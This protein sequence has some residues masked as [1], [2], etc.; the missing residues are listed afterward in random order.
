[1]MSQEMVE[2]SLSRT[3]ENL[4]AVGSCINLSQEGLEYTNYVQ[5][6]LTSDVV[7][8]M[9]EFTQHGNTS[10]FQHCVNVSY[11]SY[12]LCDKLGLDKKSAARAGLLHDLFLY[13]WHSNTEKMPLFQKHG[14]THPQKALD[15]ANQYFELNEKEEDM[16]LKHMW[17]LTISLPKYKESCIIILVDKMCCLLEFFQG[18]FTVPTQKQIEDRMLKQA[19]KE[20]EKN[21]KKSA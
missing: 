20:I 5:D 17:P 14:F 2:H 4:F 13:D 16:I 21:E 11:Y 8:S 6:L 1:M 18:I 15:N 7:L 10:C 3:K 19:R 12:L 9:K